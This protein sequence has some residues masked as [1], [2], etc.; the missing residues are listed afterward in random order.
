MISC[1]RVLG[2]LLPP[3]ATS[4]LRRLLPRA[5]KWVG[6]YPTWER[7][8]DFSS[9]YDDDD[10][11]ERVLL[12]ARK[13]R[14]GLVAFERDSVTFDAPEYVWPVL[15]G[16]LLA[17]ARNGGVLN[18]LDVGGSLGSLY[19]QHRSLIRG[20]DVRRWCVVEQPHVVEVGKREFQDR[21][22]CFHADISACLAESAPN[23]VLLSGVVQYVPEP[24]ALL[25][26]VRGVG[27]DVIVHSRTAF[28]LTD[29]DRIT[30]QKVSP[31][32]YP[33]SYPAWFLSRKRF[34]GIFQD[35]YELVATFPGS[36]GRYVPGFFEGG[37]LVC[38]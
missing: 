6:D 9:G 32:I 17:A 25:E 26:Q 4:L 28:S 7:A 22:L 16:L 3:L 33:A 35:R 15:S 19:Y 1:R 10:V 8:V 29:K 34:Y 2:Q 13:A 14:D 38:R 18:V 21:V 23:A 36:E 31:E 20:V 12:G 11:F 30:V 37:V 27:A 5:V 24:Y